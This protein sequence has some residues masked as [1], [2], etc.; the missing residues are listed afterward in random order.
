MFTDHGNGTEETDLPAYHS[1][2]LCID[3]TE[4]STDGGH[5][6]AVDLPKAPYPLGG[7]VAGVVEDVQRLGGF[8][9]IAH[10]GSKKRHS[11]GPTG[12]S[13]LTRWSGSMSTVNGET[14]LYCA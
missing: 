12:T 7:E 1:G 14:S 11:D 13:N 5:Y 4:I 8:G 9:V 6:V 2:V 3:S 10:P